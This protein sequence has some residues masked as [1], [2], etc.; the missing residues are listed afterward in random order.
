MEE[1]QKTIKAGI[2]IINRIQL[3]KSK[4]R[5]IVKIYNRKHNSKKV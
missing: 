4:L 3:P 2:T 1:F 5:L